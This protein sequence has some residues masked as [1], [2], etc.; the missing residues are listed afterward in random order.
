M[1]IANTIARHDDCADC[2]EQIA[3]CDAV[4]LDPPFDEWRN[5]PVFHN[6]TKF[7]FTN[8]QNRAYVE[9]RYGRPRFEVI[10]HFAD[11]R[12]TSHKLPRTTHEC[13]LIYGPTG[14]SYVGPLNDD[15]R[16]RKKG[17]GSVGRDRLPE[18]VYQPRRRKAL[19]S[20]VQY[21]RNVGG[22]LGCWGKPVQLMA[23]LLNWSAAKTLADPYAGSFSVSR[24]ALALPDLQVFACEI[25]K[26]TFDDGISQLKAAAAPLFS[27][28]RP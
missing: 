3:A 6:A 7:C 2:L 23:D 12:W 15:L 19:N 24:A 26:G 17:R 4:I 20:V 8:F 13:I 1:R 14:E 21:P 22:A 16:P 18:R 11:G 10:W 9:E 25:D 28:V 5:A 27:E